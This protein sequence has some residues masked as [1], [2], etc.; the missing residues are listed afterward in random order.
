MIWID[1][2]RTNFGYLKNTIDTVEDRP[3]LFVLSYLFHSL[4]ATRT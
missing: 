2:L 3:I 1:S 4:A